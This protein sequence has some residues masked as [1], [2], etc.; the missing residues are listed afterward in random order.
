MNE[1]KEKIEMLKRLGNHLVP[2]N[3]PLDDPAND[4]ILHPLKTVDLD[5]DGYHVTVHYNKSDY[6]RYILESFQVI[7]QNTPFL[8]FCVVVKLAKMAF[9]ENSN[10]LS[11]AE[12]L[13]SNRKIYIWTLTVDKRTNEPIF[14]HDED[15]LEICVYEGFEYNLMRQ[16][17]INIY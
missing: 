6:E 3:F 10:A 15:D 1:A 12:A 2:Y 4:D 16:N 13:H 11:L 9:N 5:I 8:P 17:Q 14:I 7:S